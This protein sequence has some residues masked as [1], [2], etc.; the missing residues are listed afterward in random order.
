MTHRGHPAG[1]GRR[2]SLLQYRR[3]ERRQFLLVRLRIGRS[4]DSVSIHGAAV[5][6]GFGQGEDGEALAVGGD[7]EVRGAG[8]E[9]RLVVP[10]ARRSLA[11]PTRRRT[12]FQSEAAGGLRKLSEDVGGGKKGE[13]INTSVGLQI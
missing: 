12:V 8:V 9:E 1:L 2:Q 3:G 7:V 11:R 4:S 6:G 13:G 10:G 5:G